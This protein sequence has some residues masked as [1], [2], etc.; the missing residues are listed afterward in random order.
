MNISV[1]TVS[2][3]FVAALL[4]LCA[5]LFPMNASGQWAARHGLSNA[6]YQSAFNDLVGQGYR[7]VQV[8]GYEVNGSDFYA[9]I[10]EQRTG[11]NWAARHGLTSSQYQQTF[12]ELV[13]Q[14]YRPVDVSGYNVG[15]ID[16]YAAI[17]EQR[18]DV[19]WAARH[20]LTFSEYQAAFDDFL[21]QGY[22]LVDVSGYELNGEDYY[23]AIWEQRTGPD[24]AARHGFTTAGFQT[25][26]DLLVAQGYRLV[27]RSTYTVNG[28][29]LHAGIFELVSDGAWQ[30]RSGLTSAQ[31]QETF[32]VL[33]GDGYR[34]D[35]VSGYGIGGQ[36]FYSGIWTQEEQ[37]VVEDLPMNG[38]AG[39]GLSGFDAIMQDFMKARNI[40]AGALA[41]MLDQTLVYE[42]GFGWMDEAMTTEL[43]SDALFRLASVSKPIT[44][45]AI[46]K[47]I[48]GG[49]LSASDQV[50]CI[51]STT[52]CILDIEPFGTADANVE[53]ITVQH[54]LDHEGG[55]DRNISGDPM[56][57]AIGIAN[58]MGIASPPSQE[59]ITQYM[60]GRPL[61]F[62]PGSRDAYSNFGYLVLGLVV[63]AVAGMDFTQYAQEQIFMPEGVAVSEVGLARSYEI[64]RNPREPWYSDPG[65]TSDVFNPAQ[66]VPYPDGGF[67]VEAFEAHGGLIA[68]APALTYFLDGYW[69]SGEPRSGNG[70]TY[71]F[72]G[73][74][75]GTYTYVIQRPSGV[76]IA[77]LFNQRADASGLS[78][79]AIRDALIQA[80]DGINVWPVSIEHEPNELPGEGDKILQGNFPNPFSR[81]TDILFDLDTPGHVEVTIYNALG[82]EV[83][84]ITN[85]W[86]Q[87]GRHSI[88]WEAGDLPSGVYVYRIVT[89]KGVDANQMLYVTQ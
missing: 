77:V 10:W 60:L 11:P 22:R 41:I 2:K 84:R 63:E 64:N 74:M 62:T 85:G 37:V 33:L 16:Y 52:N 35:V 89:D 3:L 28:E 53:Q 57:N 75:P 36:D 61:D 8:S 21:R 14:G 29:V 80:A 6:G 24:W 34:L 78:Y 58:T 48:A 15:G 43:P 47:L 25:E 67:H 19:A 70:G 55:W 71:Q 20:R 44:A 88:R 13:A 9:A 42:K 26:F 1:G 31:Y 39:T 83:D 7:L 30:S 45:A 12:D 38:R 66:T 81:S 50:F 5:W 40:K 18:N 87:D 82:Q 65:A 79:A 76:N 32:N 59:E 68:S 4:F 17:W 27:N 69:L 51:T 49:S 23:A 86:Y 73:S 72:N 56:F 54:L 46:K